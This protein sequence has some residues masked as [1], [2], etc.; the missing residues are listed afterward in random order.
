MHNAAT[1]RELTM[2]HTFSKAEK[3]K[4][5]VIVG[6]GPAGLEAARIAAERGHKVT[7]LEAS[8]KEGGQ[9]R[10]AAQTPRRK[11]LMSIIDWRMHQCLKHHVSFEFNCW[12]QPDDI[13]RHQ[14]DA[15]I[16]ATGGMPNTDVLSQGNDLVVSCWDILAGD[17][18]PGKNVLIFD[19]AG[20]HPA[21]Q[22]AE[23]IAQS[24]AKLEIMT[25]DRSFAPEIMAM[26]LV[27][28]MRSLQD[29]DVTFSVTYR[30]DKVEREQAQLK[31]TLSSDYGVVNKHRIIDQVVVNHGT[32]PLEALYFDLKPMSSNAGE[33]DQDAFINGTPQT[34]K[35]NDKGQFQLFRIGDA[36]AARNVHAA[37]YDAL[38]L[39][40]DI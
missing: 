6:A 37:I 40:K 18:K 15:V 2:P 34:V 19:D 39:M 22:A 17:V 16:I 33:L 25:P 30:V 13:L 21:L 12:A 28:Y 24:G 3:I 8:P 26:N 31:A 9:L 20:D 27:P 7:V 23:L 36:V 35:R 38:R 11:E 32:L 1:G 10:L 5:L 29:L 4:N 14:P